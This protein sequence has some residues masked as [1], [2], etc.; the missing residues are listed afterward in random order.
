MYILRHYRY[1]AELTCYTY[2]RGT[3]SLHMR[4]VSIIFIRYRVSISNNASSLPATT[5]C[6]FHNVVFDF[7]TVPCEKLLFWHFHAVMFLY[8][9]LPS[10]ALKFAKFAFSLFCMFYMDF[11]AK[12]ICEQNTNTKGSK[13]EVSLLNN[14]PP[15]CKTPC[16]QF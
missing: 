14:S 7:S 10:S 6:T 9:S 4:A 2:W 11:C 12:T 16:S 15:T 3:F 8:C 1:I 5:P 13:R